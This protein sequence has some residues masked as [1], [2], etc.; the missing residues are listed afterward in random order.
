MTDGRTMMA[1]IRPLSEANLA[2][3]NN[4]VIYTV[5]FGPDADATVLQ[6]IAS[7]TTELLLCI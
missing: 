1:A 6:Q 7:I 3:D 2:H 4:I 5:A